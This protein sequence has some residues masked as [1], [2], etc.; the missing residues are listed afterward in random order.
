MDDSLIDEVIRFWFDETSKPYW[1][2]RSDSFDRAVTD[3]LLAPHEAAASGAL[4]HWME[5]ADGCLAL[6]ILLD[7][8]PRNMFRGTPRAFATDEKAR[9]VAAHAVAAGMDMDFDP[10]ERVFLYLPFEH[11]EDMESQRRSVALFRDRVAE[12]DSVLYAERH[13]EIIQRF[14]RFPHRNA[15]L[16]RA[17]T[18]DEIAFLSEPNS[19]F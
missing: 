10:A 12:P 11:H 7:Q 9:A 18:P 17:S 6:C 8:A 3:R 5:E 19:S 1:F 4:D 16:G 13:L 14:G 2:Q 15:I